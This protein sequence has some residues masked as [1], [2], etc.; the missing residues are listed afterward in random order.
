MRRCGECARLRIFDL[1]LLRFNMNRKTPLAFLFLAFTA[2]PIFAQGS[3]TQPRPPATQTQTANVPVS[4]IAVIFSAAFQ[5]SKQGI[6]K[7]TVLLTKVNSEFQ[8]TQDELNQ[9]A[10]RINQLSDDL[11]KTRNIADPKVTQQKIDQ[12][13]QLKKDYKRRGEDAQVAYQKRR[14][15]VL[16]PL[17]D[18]VGKAL[19]TYAKAHAITM[20]IDGSQ[21]EGVVY[22]AES[23]DIT[24]AFI[25]DYNNK[26]PATASVTTPK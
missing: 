1:R 21:V 16:G 9:L 8:K 5:D 10:Q 18:D 26:N 14:N 12:L 6:A 24:R 15:E 13:D 17:Q 20:I 19:D 2:V 4:K 23:T 22:A 7:F 3:G 11:N 25:S